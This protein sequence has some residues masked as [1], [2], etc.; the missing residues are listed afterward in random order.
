M[1]IPSNSR[2][3]K[4][5]FLSLFFVSVAATQ[6]AIEWNGVQFGGF[7]SQGY[8][9]NSGSNDYI[10]DSS[11][12]TFDFREYA[13][14]AS[15]AKGKFRV[16]AQIFGQKLGRYGNDEVK[17][18]WAT[19]D[20]QATPWFG[21]RAGRV[22]TPR[23]LYNEMLD[24]DIVRPFILLP[25]GLY[26]PRLRDFNSSFDGAMAY[27]NLNLKA[28]GSIDYKVYYGGI[29]IA[30][31]SGANDYFNHESAFYNN[32]LELESI[33]GGWLFWNT[34]LDGLR[35]GYSFSRFT[36]L[37]STQTTPS[38][39]ILAPGIRFFKNA[40]EYDRHVWSAEYFWDEWCF[41]AE[42]GIE[43]AMAQVGA[44]GAPAS[45]VNDTEVKSWYLSATR[46][47][48]DRIE[49]GAYYN[50]YEESYFAAGFIDTTRTQHDY[51]ATVRFDVT[52]YLILKL[53]VHY[54]KEA[55]KIWDLID[56][57]QPESVRD[58][59]WTLFAAKATISF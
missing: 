52:E 42:Y 9:D 28:A 32:S 30:P 58:R 36:D 27:G 10:G 35:V 3:A 44:M 55:G 5:A 19:V 56:D 12:G 24:L 47:I 16:G 49:L 51:A 50:Y 57:R 26:D 37:N 4:R 2:A 34:P 40:P 25:S 6:A 31:D 38:D 39:Y 17:L 22:K 43:S 21:L 7:A 46:R 54:N 48:N 15:F 59:E 13:V 11:A 20:F 41:A 53:E 23:G 33:L 29:D 8:L 45:L 1:L 14:N 18:D